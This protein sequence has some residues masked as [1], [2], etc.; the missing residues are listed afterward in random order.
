M[1][2]NTSTEREP[3]GRIFLATFF[4]GTLIHLVLTANLYIPEVW[5]LR[6]LCHP[7][8]WNI[9]QPWDRPLTHSYLLYG[10]TRFFFQTQTWHNNK[11]IIFFPNLL[12]W[13][14][15]EFKS[16]M[17][18]SC[19][20]GQ[21]GDC[22]VGGSAG[23]HQSNPW[24]LHVQSFEFEEVL[25]GHPSQNNVWRHAGKGFLVKICWTIFLGF[26]FF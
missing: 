21:G 19:L 2:S 4:R 25:L 9:S 8:E 1:Q 15:F 10:L 3:P 22:S 24:G 7:W 6:W 26:G 17:S 12:H 5:H 14:V 18:I 11:V 23:N 16:F 20:Q 13:W